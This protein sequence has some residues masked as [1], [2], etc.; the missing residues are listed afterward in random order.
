MKFENP[1]P[2]RGRTGR[3]GIKY[4]DEAAELRSNPGEWAILDERPLERRTS[5]NAL[6]FQIREGRYTAFR[7][8]GQWDTT[9]RRVDDK[10]RVYI[11]FTGE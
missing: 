1:A 2:S 3:A 7:P 8:R 11:R 9:T 5:A 4:T 6:A 10:V